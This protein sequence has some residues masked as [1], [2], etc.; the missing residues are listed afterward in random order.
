[1]CRV[2]SFCCGCSLNAGAIT[3]AILTLLKVVISVIGA[4]MYFNLASDYEKQHR[5]TAAK[6]ER[7]LGGLW[8]FIAILGTINFVCLVLAI[9]QDF[10]NLI[11][12]AGLAFWIYIWIVVWSFYQELKGNRTVV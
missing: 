9:K 7:I 1:M 4:G 6:E 2:N 12:I 11:L 5:D 10:A 3:A 8:I